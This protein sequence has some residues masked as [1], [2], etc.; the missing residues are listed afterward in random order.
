MIKWLINLIT[1][2]KE[3]QK[4]LREIHDP[5][6]AERHQKRLPSTLYSDIATATGEGN[7]AIGYQSMNTNN[8]AMIP[9]DPKHGVPRVVNGTYL[10]YHHT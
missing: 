9:Y 7:V 3:Y 2:D 1:Q 5:G 10:G 8:W 6:H 4:Q